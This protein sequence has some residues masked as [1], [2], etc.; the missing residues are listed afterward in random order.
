MGK[1]TNGPDWTDISVYLSEITEQTG[2]ELILVIT[3][4]GSPG[5]LPLS[6][7]LLANKAGSSPWTV[8][9]GWSVSAQWPNR[10][11][12]TLEGCV[13]AACARVDNEIRRQS[14]LDIMLDP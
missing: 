7:C 1:P 11:N 4:G 5:G 12:K 10:E 9:E 13:F 14:V 8:G 6:V 2:C 3:P